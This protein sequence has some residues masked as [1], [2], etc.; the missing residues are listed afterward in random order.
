M[1]N[2]SPAV[3]CASLNLVHLIFNFLLLLLLLLLGGCNRRM[4]ALHF[5]EN[6]PGT[7]P[8]AKHEEVPERRPVP[9]GVAAAGTNTIP[10]AGIPASKGVPENSLQ[11]GALP[12]SVVNSLSF[13]LF[14]ARSISGSVPGSFFLLSFLSLFLLDSHE[15]L[16]VSM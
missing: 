16:Q 8:T 14:L 12:I 1:Q 15:V 6:A 4:A 3:L 5:D 9:V 7:L 11:E 10:Q 2:Q 13:S